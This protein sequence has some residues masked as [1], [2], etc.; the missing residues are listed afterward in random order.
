MLISVITTTLFGH[1]HTYLN[2]PWVSSRAI[3]VDSAGVGVVDFDIS[4]DEIQA[5]YARGYAAAQDFLSSWDWRAYL[6]KWRP[7]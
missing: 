1:D 3:R 5:S 4:E 7:A 6:D 2:Q